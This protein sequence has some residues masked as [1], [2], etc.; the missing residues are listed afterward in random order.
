MSKKSIIAASLKKMP[1]DDWTKLKLTDGDKRKNPLTF[2]MINE[3][4]T[5]A[6]EFN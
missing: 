4:I 6:A 3:D 2:T 5:F 1:D